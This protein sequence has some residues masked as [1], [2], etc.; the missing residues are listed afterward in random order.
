LFLV[1]D[2]VDRRAANEQPNSLILRDVAAYVTRIMTVFG[3]VSVDTPIGF[4]ISGTA[5]AGNV[6]S[7]NCVWAVI[8]HGLV[9]SFSVISHGHFMQNPGVVPLAK[10]TT[11]SLSCPIPIPS[12]PSLSS[13]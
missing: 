1:L 8:L 7:E 11:F 5:D 3:A 4:P 9:Q 10:G 12:P 2:N 6:S 13:N